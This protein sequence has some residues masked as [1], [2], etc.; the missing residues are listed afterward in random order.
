MTNQRSQE[1][2]PGVSVITPD[3]GFG[4]KLLIV[5]ILLTVLIIISSVSGV[6]SN[7]TLTISNSTPVDSQIPLQ[8]PAGNESPSGQPTGIAAILA[9]GTQQVIAALTTVPTA[10]PTEVS[11]SSSLNAV[12][13][14]ATPA[15]ETMKTAYQGRPPLVNPVLQQAAIDH[16]V[17]LMHN[18]T[19]AQRMT[20]ARNAA[21]QGLVVGVTG[22]SATGDYR[23]AALVP[24][25]GGTPD[26]FGPYSNYANSQLPSSDGLGNVMPGTGIRKFVDSL[27][28][29]GPSQANNL[30]QYIPVAISDTVSYPGSEYYEIGLVQYTEKMHSDINPT[31]LRGYV[32]LETPVNAGTSSHFALFYPNGSPIRNTTGA[33][34]YGYE[35]PHYLGPLIVANRNVPVRIKFHNYLATGTD[36]D[37]FIPVDT[38]QMGAGTGSNGSSVYKENR[39]TIHLHGGNTPW[40]SDGTPHQWTTPAGENTPYPEGVSVKNVPDMDGGNE[41]VGTLTFYYTNQQSARLLFYHDHAYGITRLNVYAGEAGGM[42]V[43]DSAEQGLI[44]SGAIPTA[45]V[46]L[47]IQDKSFV[48]DAAQINATDPTWNWGNPSTPW[49]HTGSFW[50]NHV[51]M[52]LQNPSDPTNTNAMGRWDYGPWVWP[53]FTGFLNQPV[54]N[55]YYDP[56]NAPWEPPLMPATPN[57]ST[58]PESFMD[59]MVVN[60]AVY[61]Y[62]QLGPHAYRFRILNACND[63]TLNLQLYYAGSNTTMWSGTALLNGSAGE[64]P[65]VSANR[66]LT[67]GLPPDWPTDDRD[68]GV[69]DP[70]ARGPSW[71]RIGTEGGF[72]PAPEVIPP[73]PVDY[74][75]KHQYGGVVNIKNHSLLLM[76]AQRGDIIVDFT[77]IPNGAKLILYNDAPAPAPGGDSRYDYYTGDPDQT[78]IGGAPTTFAGYAP[79]TRTIMQI[80]I[81]SSIGQVGPAF[82]LATLN[83]QLPAAYA[84]FQDKPIVPEAAYNPAFGASYP[85]QYVNLTNTSITFVPAGGSSLTTIQLQPKTI[86]GDF[87]MD[88][89]RLT[90]LL[91]TEIRRTDDNIESRVPAGYIDPPTEVLKNSVNATLIGS[92][93]DGTQIWRITNNDVDLHPVHWH[94]VNLQ[95]INRVIWDGT[96]TPPDP[97]ELGWRETINTPPLTDTI[98]ALRPITPDLPWELPNSIRPLDVTQQLGETDRFTGLDPTGGQAPVANHLVNFGWEYVWHCH[99]LGHEENDFM[100]AMA[101]AVAPRIPPSNLRAELIGTGSTPMVILTWADN[102]VSETNWTVQRSLA[103]TGPWTDIAMIPS[104]TGPQTGSSGSYSDPTVTLNTTYY[105]QVLATNIVGD[106]T[107]YSW[108]TGYPYV[109]VN[110]TPSA[111]AVITVSNVT[112]GF[113]VGVYRPSVH[114][115][116]LKNG[117]A[118]SWTTTAINWGISTDLPVTG[119]WNGDGITDVGVYRPSVHTFLLKNGTT[120]AINWGIS[121]DLPVTGDWNGDGITDVGVYRPSSH[122]FYLKNGTT[123]AINWGV[124][125]DLP[126]T[127]K[128]S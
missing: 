55:P 125:T 38:S 115:F 110:S 20:A 117:T 52:P 107:H 105:Y 8:T 30:G 127:G 50:Y 86:I 66:T 65:I 27:P 100:H 120:T 123:T 29:L 61:P 34:V 89:G 15:P 24:Q 114:T 45:E 79:N 16:K 94:M 2:K 6:S 33:Q 91:G 106:T 35:K 46:P 112:S 70:T 67:P 72:M 73:R 103:P 28:G 126:V 74:D 25:R 96:V 71:I 26:Y 4:G 85:T 3:S 62:V 31:V 10:Q 13:A 40:I 81:N 108:T 49:P 47:I 53:P 99:I 93:S 51:Y 118:L 101:V 18:I 60:G 102:S 9:T 19:T 12:V 77:G 111:P 11:P 1:T 5:G 124:S 88:Y 128:W 7:T 54:A 104:T 22:S 32:Q 14:A 23:I 109:V 36:G 98:V 42:I 113:G 78:L 44:A 21:A 48:P 68:G 95:V 122:M 90:A 83:A 56:V 119:D 37:L 41:P 116:Y 121:T 63:R 39:A 64:V 57:P 69:P 17:M 58:S 43:R 76:P 97:S 92:L 82:S 87:E 59:T 75:L 84:Q 80:Q